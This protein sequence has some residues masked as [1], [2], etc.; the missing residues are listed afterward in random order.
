M[1]VATTPLLTTPRGTRG[2][3]GR[4]LADVTS[5]RPAAAWVADLEA[6]FGQASPL[7]QH[8]PVLVAGKGAVDRLLSRAQRLGRR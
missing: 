2:L 3:R 8:V 5:T 7:H 4:H 1:T 6:A